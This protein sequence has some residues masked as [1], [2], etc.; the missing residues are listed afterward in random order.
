MFSHLSATQPPEAL[1]CRDSVS[2]YLGPLPDQ[3]RAHNRRNAQLKSEE[4]REGRRK[5]RRVAFD[6]KQTA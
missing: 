1:E 4:R 2:F 5:K 6:R 3:N